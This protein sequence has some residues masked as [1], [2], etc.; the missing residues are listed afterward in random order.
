LIDED[1][2]AA[3]GVG[4]AGSSATGRSL[5]RDE[6]SPV[7]DRCAVLAIVVEAAR[8]HSAGARLRS[9]PVSNLGLHG[10]GRSLLYHLLQVTFRDE[11]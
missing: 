11:F 8:L 3:A 1:H 9:L 10:A 5:L 6:R 7:S 4:E 2:L